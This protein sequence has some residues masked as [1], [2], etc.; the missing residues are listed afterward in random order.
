MVQEIRVC[1]ATCLSA[2]SLTACQN[3][4]SVAPSPTKI[5]TD[6]LDTT[7]SKLVTEGSVVGVSALIYSDNQEIYYGDF[8]DADREADKSW[9]RDTLATIYSMTKPV[10]G[11]TL[12]SLYEEGLFEMDAPLSDYLPEYGGVKVFSGVR[13]D[14]SLML[15]TP[16]RPIKVI[17]IFRHTACFGYG[18]GD[19]TVSALMNE[20]QIMDPSKPLSQ[21]SE[22]LAELPLYCH[23]GEAWKYSVAVDVQA[24]LAEV[25]TGKPFDQLVQERVLGP[26]KMTDTSYFVPSEKK[27]R[28]AAIYAKGPDG[29][30]TRVPDGFVTLTEPTAIWL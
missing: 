10:A 1:L 30:L 7:L 15:E 4:S 23:P 3:T 13:D 17:D 29:S 21:F 14:G 24:R 28:V 18:W 16:R 2:L 25:I 19:D 27:S 22:E 9:Q 5:N 11:V 26:L 8:G 12:M 6:I 20:A